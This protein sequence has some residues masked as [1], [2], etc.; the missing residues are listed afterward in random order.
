M[1]E[2]PEVEWVRRCLAPDLAGRT[3][4]EVT[5]RHPGI[6]REP[7]PV[8]FARQLSGARIGSLGRRGKYLLASLSGPRWLA[9]H[10]GMSGH[11]CLARSGEP[12]AAH[13]HARFSLGGQTELRFRDVRRFGGL[14]LFGGEDPATWHRLA[15]LGPEPL[16]PSFTEAAWLARCG[17]RSR[18]R[19]KGILLD[20]SFVAGI[21]NIYADE[22]LFDAGIDPCR[23]LAD[24][25]EE[26]RRA[27]YA[28]LRRVLARA[29][30]LG[31][32]SIRDYVDANGR[33]GHY[34]ED[35]QVYGRGGRP[36]F[37][38][39]GELQRLQVAGRTTVRCRRCQR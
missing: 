28:S 14:F 13:T 33:P 25:G 7:D 2:L 3:I 16:D 21:G 4:G 1:P 15:V 38:C 12:L 35:H 36:C 9:V 10:L 23:D 5:I 19:I 31:G 27:L 26:A 37:R 39:N 17:S 8:S 6:V 11:L 24:L 20:Q 22:I 32:S 30:S 18:G 34:Q 29:V